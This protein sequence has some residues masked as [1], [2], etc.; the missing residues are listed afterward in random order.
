M[1][2]EEKEQSVAPDHE[3]YTHFD[4]AEVN[5]NETLYEDP[6]IKITNRHVVLRSYWFPFGL[7]KVIP[8][9]DIKHCEIRRNVPMFEMKSWGMGVDL[10]VWWHMDFAKVF[11]DRNAIILDVGGWPKIGFCPA[12]GEIEAVERVYALINEHCPGR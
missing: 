3:K 5:Q 2:T 9:G 7:K 1:D 12:E 4:E 11:G 6:K 8:F 10:Q